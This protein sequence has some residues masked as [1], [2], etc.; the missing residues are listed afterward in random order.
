MPT[1][2]VVGTYDTKGLEHEFVAN[3]IR[4]LGHQPLLID[5][6]GFGD[7]RV[8]VDVTCQ[9]VAELAAIDL[10]A[11]RVQADRGALV[12]AMSKAAPVL[13][14]KLVKEGRVQGVVSLG[15][16]GGTAIGTAAMRALP[17]GFPKV[18]VST[19]A[20]KDVSAYVDVSDIIM[21]PSIVDVSGL[22]RISRDVFARAAAVVV[23]L[24]DTQ[25]RIPSTMN[26]EP[27]ALATG[28]AQNDIP[29]DDK[30]KP[31][32]SVY[33]SGKDCNKP[34]IVASMFGNTTK[35]VEHARKLLE[36]AGFE[37]LVFHATGT[38]GRTMEAIIES[39]VVAGVL[40]LTTTEW[41]DELVGG[42]MRGGPHRLE[43]AA[44]RGIPAIIAPGCLDMVNFGARDT[45][46]SH[47][48][49]RVFYQHNPQITLMRTTP[50]ECEQLGK[51]IA[52]KLN[53]SVGSVEV[54]FPLRAL[55]I[56]SAAGQP[57]HNPWADQSL[58]ES[59]RKH[60]RADIDLT[61]I[62]CEINDPIFAT[63]CAERLLKVLSYPSKHL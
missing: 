42:V 50:E 34:L 15:G 53:A 2:A 56:I 5:V 40:D 61:M 46:P 3:Q 1:I 17:L 54:L 52:Q 47:F 49:D 28:D 19:M 62:D 9:Q 13:L 38:G 31:E 10:H 36:G 7:A 63:Q 29:S 60:L 35:C 37:V 59:L 24:A 55:S 32:V 51:I 16:T 12:A 58:L 39:G 14:A 48:S 43:A 30:S 21:I 20:G 11:L 22:N 25:S 8:P 18:M 26:S 57:F 6:G 44:R 4:A 27:M 33:S 23:A 41:A 45:V